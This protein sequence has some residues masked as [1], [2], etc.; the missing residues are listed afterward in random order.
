[1]ADKIVTE[2]E[3]VLQ[4]V[5]AFFEN[6]FKKVA[7]ESHTALAEAKGAIVSALTPKTAATTQPETPPAE[8]KT[9]A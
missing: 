4:E 9:E 3:A 5:E 1:M 8:E 6:L 2:A 7:A